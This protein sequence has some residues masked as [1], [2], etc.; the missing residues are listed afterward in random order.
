[1]LAFVVPV[2]FVPGVYRELPQNTCSFLQVLE[3]KME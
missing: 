3:L 2:P 1:M